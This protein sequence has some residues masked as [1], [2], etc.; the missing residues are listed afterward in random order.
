MVAET[1]SHR[2]DIDPDDIIT[3]VAGHLDQIESAFEV[4]SQRMVGAAGLGT[5]RRMVVIHHR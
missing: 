1:H 3:L 5:Q 4:L 2:D